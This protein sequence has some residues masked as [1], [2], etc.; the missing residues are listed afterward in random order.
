MQKRKNV[1]LLECWRKT[2]DKPHLVFSL[3][4]LQFFE[5]CG[6]FTRPTLLVF[7]FLAQ[8]LQCVQMAKPWCHGV[9]GACL[10]AWTSA[11]VMED[12]FDKK[13]WAPHF[14]WYMG[15]S[16]NRGTPKWMVK[17]ME[18]PIKMDDLGG[19]THYF[20]N[21]PYAWVRSLQLSTLC[22]HF[23]VLFFLL[24][25]AKNR[26]VRSETLQASRWNKQRESNGKPLVENEHIFENMAHHTPNKFKCKPPFLDS[27]QN[28]GH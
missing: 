2:H 1:G 17:I 4:G 3:C 16:K 12:N 9:F 20:R 8:V 10:D 21:P 11:S 7:Q 6:N 5:F 24:L 13:T 25:Q 28:K 15:V 14:F 22:G 27:I 23:L 26:K 19:K 18:N